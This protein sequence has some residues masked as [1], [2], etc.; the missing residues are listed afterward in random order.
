GEI[1]GYRV[2]ILCLAGG[3]LH[4]RALVGQRCGSGEPPGRPARTPAQSRPHAPAPLDTAAV[5]RSPTRRNTGRAAWPAG[6]AA[7]PERIAITGV[8]PRESC[9][10]RMPPPCAGSEIATV[11]T[12]SPAQRGHICRTAPVADLEPRA[13]C[14]RM[15]AREG[16]DLRPEPTLCNGGVEWSVAW[17]A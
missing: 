3:K 10:R 7:C 1:H 17:C 9:K 2:V 5:D 13:R 12:A 4:R 14:H 8:N 15:W 16:P 6:F 11:L